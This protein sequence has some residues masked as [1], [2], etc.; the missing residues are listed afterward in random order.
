[1]R[2]LRAILSSALAALL[3]AMAAAQAWPSQTI[4]LSSSQA[5]AG[6][7]SGSSSRE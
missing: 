5:S 3:P 6:A 7:G 2:L 1:M 4:S